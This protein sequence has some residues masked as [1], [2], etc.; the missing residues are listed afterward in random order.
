MINCIVPQELEMDNINSGVNV[1]LATLK[2]MEYGGEIRAD[3]ING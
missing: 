2:G 3:A 1:E